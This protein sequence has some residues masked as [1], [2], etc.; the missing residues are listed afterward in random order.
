MRMAPTGT[1]MYLN[2]QLQLVNCLGRIRRCG[3]V[4][5]GLSLGLNFQ[6]F[7]KPTPGQSL[8]LLSVDMCH[9][10]LPAYCHDDL[11]LT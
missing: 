3:L 6:R 4:G 11:G 7:Q 10:S 9:A 8:F 2:F 5:G 1:Y